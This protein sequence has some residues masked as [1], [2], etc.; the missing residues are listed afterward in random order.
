MFKLRKCLLTTR[1]VRCTFEIVPKR[2]M[3]PLYG[4]M[5]ALKLLGLMRFE[6][7]GYPSAR[8]MILTYLLTDLY[9]EGFEVAYSSSLKVAISE[10]CQI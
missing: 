3:T 8:R 6:P 1:S 10:T 5:Q 4:T 7:T 9:T 2:R